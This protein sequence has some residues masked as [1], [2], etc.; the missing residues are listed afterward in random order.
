MN[1]QSSLLRITSCRDEQEHS[2][3]KFLLKISLF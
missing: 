3:S 1:R 2:L